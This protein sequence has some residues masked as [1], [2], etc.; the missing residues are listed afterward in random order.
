[1]KRSSRPGPGQTGPR[2]TFRQ[3]LPHLFENRSLM[4]G[5]VAISIVGALFSLA[6]PVLVAVLIAEV[7]RG[8]LLGWLVWAL[9]GIVLLG[10]L[11]Q[12]LQH[13]LLQRTGESIVLSTRRKLV[14][15]LLRLPIVEFD[16]R[17]TGDLVSRV[18]SDTTLLRAVLTQGLIEAVGGAL[19]FLGAVIAMIVLDPVL[20][21]VTAG[22]VLF[23]AV[24]VA[25]LGPRIRA[26]SAAAQAKV[27][28]LTAA[29]ERAVT[30]IRAIRA[31]G[32]TEREEAAVDAEAYGAYLRG[33]D[34]A[35]VSALVVPASGFAV[36][37][38]LIAVLG[39]GG[40][41]VASG[42]LTI[43][44]LIAFIM[45]LFMMIMPLGLFF[46]AV[47]AVNTALGALGRIQEIVELPAEDAGD[48]GPAERVELC[49]PANAQAAPEA[50]AIEFRGVSFR[51]P[52]DA[53]R[54][55]TARALAIQRLD[56]LPGG[57]RGRGFGGGA[58]DETRR[59]FELDEAE[60]P[61]SPLVLD[62]VSFRVPRGRRVA[63]VGPSGAG[64]STVL[65]LIE[66]FYDPDAGSIL[67]GGVDVRE[68]ARDRLRAQIGYVQQD[69]PALAGTLRDNLL[70][71]RPDASDRECAE[72][73]RAVNLGGV[74]DRSPE[75]LSAPV[76]EAGV[77][78]SGGER[79]RL[80][81]A[82]TLL[83][84]P[85][86]LLLDESTSAL[87][88]ANEHAM[89]QAIDRVAENRSL[90]I[91]AHRLSTVVDSDTIV[92][93]DHG[94]VLGQGGHAELLETV[95]LYRELAR[96]QLLVPS[97]GQAQ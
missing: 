67:L 41:R 3:L 42:D 20:F 49:G 56:R 43:A 26:A 35:R 8:R 53:V 77:T 90:V 68:V 96:H 54:A 57:D 73:L 83:A 27:G 4:A 40:L 55:R 1:M 48:P 34:V 76:G 81:I 17:R 80:A 16:A 29:V 36:Q 92:V 25:L 33:L 74:L 24:L 84:A 18:G 10:S 19:T 61:A 50:P 37:A 65:A 89:K 63:L 45:F 78:L 85:P 88:G 47:M 46:G 64:K 69:A 38:A 31:A 58:P 12:G 32:A 6:Q 52:D 39:V 13:F 95:P 7:E 5:I 82:R 51:Y 75:G 71:G 22:I 2:A 94:R 15:R 86:V 60:R 23:A 44:N 79:Q 70:L 93:L 66:R 14:A 59:L 97:D 87:D 28:D 9:V 91:V 21:A 62:G 72:V 11:V 30:N